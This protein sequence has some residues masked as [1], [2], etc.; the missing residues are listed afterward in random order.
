MCM[1]SNKLLKIATRKI[2]CYK[3]ILEWSEFPD[4]VAYNPE[5]LHHETP[6]QRKLISLEQIKGKKPFKAKGF[7]ERTRAVVGN[8]DFGKFIYEGGLIHTYQSLEDI[9]RDFRFGM[10]NKDA[11]KVYKCYITPGTRYVDGIDGSSDTAC[12]ASKK[13]V[14]GEEIS[15]CG[16]SPYF[17]SDNNN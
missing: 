6:Y 13:I 7:T 8:R 14:F 1:Y 17:E 10:W 12:Y 4:L 3:V 5:F 15:L 9:K 16:I 2:E 11:V